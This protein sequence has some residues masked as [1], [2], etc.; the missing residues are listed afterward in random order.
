[1]GLDREGSEGGVADNPGDMICEITL[2]YGDDAVEYNFGE[3]RPASISGRVHSATTSDCFDHKLTDP[4]AGVTI[5]LLD[6]A[7]E[8]IATTKTDS[9]GVYSFTGLEP[10]TYAVRETQPEGY[11]DGLEKAGTVGGS[12]RGVVGADDLLTQIV[13]N[14]DEHGVGYDFCETPPA[15]LSG[16]V[17]IDGAPIFLNTGETLPEDVT[18][19]RDGVRTVDDTPI[20]G[21]TV[22]LVNGRNGSPVSPE[23]TLPGHYSGPFVEV[24]TDA[25]GYYEFTGLGNGSFGVVQFQPED[26]IDGTDRPGTLGGLGVNPDAGGPNDLVNPIM[27]PVEREIVD[28]FRGLFGNNA[29]AAINLTPGSASRENNFSEVTTDSLVIPPTPD[30][31]PAPPAPVFLGGITP[32][33]RPLFPVDPIP[34]AP[35][36]VTPRTGMVSGYTWHLSVI[37]A[38][39]PRADATDAAEARLR[40]A[41]QSVDVSAWS[42][43]E[44]SEEDLR[45]ARWQL[46]ASDV[47]GADLREA[48]FGNAEAVPVAGD[49]DGDGVT[50]IGVYLAGDW[51]LDLNGDGRW[52]HRD[53]WAKL[54]SQDDIPVTGDWDGDGK[55]D[56]GIYG[57]AWPRDPVAIRHE[58]GLPDA[59]NT[60]GPLA[61]KA[62]NLPPTADEA[63]SGARL[64]KRPRV[65]E[66]RSDVIDH[67]FHYGAAGDAPVAGD[68]N[69][70]GVRTIGVFRDGVWNLDSDGDGRMEPTDHTVRLGRAGDRPIVGDWDGDGID[71]LGVYRDGEWLVDADGDGG[72]EPMD[73]GALS[74]ATDEALAGRIGPDGATDATGMPITGAPIV[75]DWDGDGV[76]EAGVYTPGDSDGATP[77]ES[78]RVSQR[79]AG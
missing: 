77:D 5:E 23:D 26:V 57:P 36:P 29:I 24:T 66:R 67:V 48:L 38:G 1:D 47:E 39:R 71:E 14:S 54:G 62:K 30:P 46:I 72:L 12:T 27:S 28:R 9:D 61:G 25:R 56:I 32:G 16:Y 68:F 78:I 63:T 33:A 4:I 79:R 10:G 42:G 15:T 17:F 31:D 13:L 11:F 8:V 65:A 70:D 18:A 40:F 52:D 2:E 51:Y 75:G 69:G 55:T 19:I 37:N 21:V 7:G 53:L 44:R 6:A 43:A 3:L 50:D 58:P 22:R 60:P 64:L 49:W 76:D 35:I 34:E 45:R 59:A 74:A 73:G 20:E 41:S